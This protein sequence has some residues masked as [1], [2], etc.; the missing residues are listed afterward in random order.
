M[1]SK[2]S[3]GILESKSLYK[4]TYMFPNLAISMIVTHV[5]F[6]MHLKSMLNYFSKVT[7]LM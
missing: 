6:H 4:G 1:F 3:R 5:Q 2:I 7:I